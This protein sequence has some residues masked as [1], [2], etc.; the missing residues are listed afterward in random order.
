M[1]LI[2]VTASVTAGD[3]W[4]VTLQILSV[5]AGAVPLAIIWLR[6]KQRLQARFLCRRLETQSD[7]FRNLLNALEL[8]ASPLRDGVSQEM[9]FALVQEVSARLESGDPRAWIN[10]SFVR[11]YW[12]ETAA[13]I[14]ISISLAAAPPHVLV[15]GWNRLFMGEREELFQHLR[16]T[17]QNARVPSGSNAEILVELLHQDFPAPRLYVSGQSGWEEVMP[18][19]T[20]ANIFT[21]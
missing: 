19:P 15:T 20:D 4:R 13:L 14:F 1:I 3:S 18:V 8:S 21:G 17:P 5:A 10:C 16:I 6:L 9:S 7:S 12:R 2:L 11:R